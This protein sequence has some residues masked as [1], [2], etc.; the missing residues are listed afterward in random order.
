MKGSGTMTSRMVRASLRERLP[1][2]STR[3]CGRQGFWRATAVPPT[4]MD[5]ITKDNSTQT[6]VTVAEASN[7]LMDRNTMVI[8]VTTR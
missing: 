3:G 7:T 2:G 4:R 1:S 6:P 8:S 5:R